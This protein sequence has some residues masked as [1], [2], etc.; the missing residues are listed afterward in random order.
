M[1]LST[2]RSQHEDNH[3]IVQLRIL[4]TQVRLIW[5]LE[6]KNYA[7]FFSGSDNKDNENEKTLHKCCITSNLSFYYII[8]IFYSCFI[9]GWA[10]RDFEKYVFAFKEDDKGTTGMVNWT[11]VFNKGWKW[12]KYIHLYGISAI[13]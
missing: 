6:L 5:I 7:Y 8:Q 10:H 13:F 2:E 1:Q 11:K 3:S 12:Y 9:L 4:R